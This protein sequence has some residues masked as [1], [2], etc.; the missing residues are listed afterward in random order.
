M[1]SQSSKLSRP[2]KPGRDAIQK[3]RPQPVAIRV[4]TLSQRM[5]I[6][7][8][9]LAS[10]LQETLPPADAKRPGHTKTISN[11]SL[12]SS[13]SNNAFKTSISSQPT[14]P[15]ALLAA[16]RKKEQDERE[17]QRKLEQKRELERKRAAQQEEV[18]RQEQRQRLEA[19]KKERERIAAEQAKRAAQQQ[20]IEKKRLENLKKTEQQRNERAANEPVSDS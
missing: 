18:R 14:K 6:T 20:A 12:Q 17:V 3:P 11:T 13:T 15:K 19:E 2:T 7:T 8:A 5:P 9:T 10:T 4:G 16:E 1:P